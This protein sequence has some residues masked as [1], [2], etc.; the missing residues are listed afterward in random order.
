MDG[1]AEGRL[2]DS[3]LGTAPVWGR[4]GRLKGSLNE[5]AQII[6]HIDQ[7]PQFF[8]PPV[9]QRPR[10]SNVFL[11]VPGPFNSALRVAHRETER[12]SHVA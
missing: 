1:E 7:N 10:H 3:S 5:L 4:F 11:A 8:R 12:T 2:E 9:T 6:G